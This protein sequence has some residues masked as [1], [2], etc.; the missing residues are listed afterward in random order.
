MKKITLLLL[1]ACAIGVNATYAQTN[2]EL[3]LSK[4]REAIKIGRTGPL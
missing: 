4:A 2:K 1:L 3:A